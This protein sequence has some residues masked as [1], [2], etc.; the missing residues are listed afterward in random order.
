MVYVPRH[1]LKH[2]PLCY[3][4]SEYVQ[5]GFTEALALISF[6]TN[7]TLFMCGDAMTALSVKS[8]MQVCI[9]VH[10]LKHR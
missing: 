8:W 6:T 1:L 2:R 3:I 10:F 5:T 4:L 9:R 7:A